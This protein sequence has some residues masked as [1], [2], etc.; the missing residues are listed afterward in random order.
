MH[1]QVCIQFLYVSLWKRLKWNYMKQCKVAS[2]PQTQTPDWAARSICTIDEPTMTNM[3][4]PNST[5]P[6]GKEFSP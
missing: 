1:V 4:N 6:M 5:G 2:A 3:K